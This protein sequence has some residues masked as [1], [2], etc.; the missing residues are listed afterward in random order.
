MG[1]HF[2]I[3]SMRDLS[4]SLSD[5]NSPETTL[6][7]TIIYPLVMFCLTKDV[8]LTKGMSERF[9]RKLRNNIE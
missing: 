2:P 4:C 3:D 9:K 1:L 6:F 5:R 8:A 7:P